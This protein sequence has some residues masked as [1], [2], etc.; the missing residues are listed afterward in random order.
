MGH[1]R[2]LDDEIVE[3]LR[4]ETRQH[5]HLRPA[6]HLEHADGIG[7]LQHAVDGAVLLRDGGKGEKPLLREILSRI[8]PAKG[9]A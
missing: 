5:R 6:L 1:D 9:Q 2:D 7:A 3:F 8:F 4:L